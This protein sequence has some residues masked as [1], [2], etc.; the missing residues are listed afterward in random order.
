M[1]AGTP[2]GSGASGLS[3]SDKHHAKVLRALLPHRIL[4][5]NQK[6]FACINNC[7]GKYN[8]GNYTDHL[9]N[10]TEL[11]LLQYLSWLRLTCSF[12]CSLFWGADPCACPGTAM[13]CWGHPPPFLP[14]PL[15]WLPCGAGTLGYQV[16][17][18]PFLLLF[19]KHSEFSLY[20][21]KDIVPPCLIFL[22]ASS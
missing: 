21:N 9:L 13:S 5:T 20:L 12:L 16:E 14:S 8:P 1:A 19:L 3:V 15:S 11:H 18:L 22:L 2:Q 10:G 17:L 4:K 7:K 6:P